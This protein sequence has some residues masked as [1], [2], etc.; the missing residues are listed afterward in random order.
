MTD[1]A[2]FAALPARA[3]GDERLAA[4]DLRV[5]AAIAVHDRFG[6]NG[7]GC[8]AG[9]G[10]LAEIVGCHLKS[11]SRSIRTLAECG[12]VGGKANPLNPKYRAYFVIYTDFDEEFL[13]STV[14]RT[15]NRSATNSSELEVTDPLPQ[16]PT[17]GNE[18][19][20]K[21]GAR[22]NQ[23]SKNAQQNQEDA[24]YN[25]FPEGD[26]KSC[27]ASLR[28]PAEAAP[29]AKRRAHEAAPGKSD[30]AILGMIER[31]IKTGMKRN[32]GLQRLAWLRDRLHSGELEYRSPE[33]LRADRLHDELKRLLEAA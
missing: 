33:Y 4:L 30:G 23:A 20:P 7:V 13:R 14:G 16:T 31:S 26:K 28:D 5:L 22:G 2:H 17:R 27:E 1:K 18:L 24:S 6:K 15:G 21:T 8:T 10:R 19:V 32:E 11:L 9:H 12:Y 25:I 3:I 29:M